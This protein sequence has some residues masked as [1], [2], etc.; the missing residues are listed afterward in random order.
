MKV[1]RGFPGVF[2]AV[3][4]F[5]MLGTLLCGGSNSHKCKIK[6]RKFLESI[7]KDRNSENIICQGFITRLSLK[8]LRGRE[9]IQVGD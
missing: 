6:M 2:K 4:L 8:V 9:Y 7:K 1:L 3:T 5:V